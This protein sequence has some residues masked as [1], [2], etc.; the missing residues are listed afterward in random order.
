MSAY[1]S[2]KAALVVFTGIS[3]DA[4]HILIGSGVYVAAAVLMKAER[5]SFRPVLPVLALAILLEV[6]DV[7]DFFVYGGTYDWVD[8]IKDILLSVLLP[9]AVEAKDRW[10]R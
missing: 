6:L 7:R 8:S 2:L 3:K 1:Q 5:G 10:F 9:L 4:F